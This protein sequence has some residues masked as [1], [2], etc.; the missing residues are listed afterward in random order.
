MSIETQKLMTTALDASNS[1]Q[2]TIN[3]LAQAQ[4]TVQQAQQGIKQPYSIKDLA[5]NAASRTLSS[6]E[7]EEVIPPPGYEHDFKESKDDQQE[8]ENENQHDESDK[9]NHNATDDDSDDEPKEDPKAPEHEIKT[10]KMSGRTL[11]AEFSKGLKQGITS[12]KTKE[13]SYEMQA[14][15]AK[16]KLDG[17][18]T[19]YYPDGKIEREINFKQGKMHGL[20]RSFHENG[21]LAMEIEYEHGVMHGAS[22]IYDELGKE[23]VISHYQKGKLHGD[24]VVFSNGKPYLKNVYHEGQETHQEYDASAAHSC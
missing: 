12:I 17:P 2:E 14:T 20:M 19:Y 8:F 5:K 21:K 15:Y 11:Q 3:A 6:I 9:G 7:M 23:Q 16:G 10:Q 18:T 24:T 22:K 1:N 4:T 13:G